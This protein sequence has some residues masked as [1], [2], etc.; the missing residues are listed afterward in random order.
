MARTRALHTRSSVPLELKLMEPILG[1]TSLQSGLTHARVAAVESLVAAFD[2]D[3]HK[4][5]HELG[6]RDGATLNVTTPHEI[7]L[8]VMERDGDAVHF[9]L[10]SSTRLQ[11]LIDAYCQREDLQRRNAVFTY[12][13]STGGDHTSR[14]A[15]TPHALALA[16]APDTVPLHPHA[17]ATPTSPLRTNHSTSCVNI[18]VRTG[19][20]GHGRCHAVVSENEGR[21]YRLRPPDT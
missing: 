9:K 8:K 18:D 13:V 14:L 17:R 7:N 2:V 15:H 6:L 4:S 5:P 20:V 21:R 1:Q 12:N 19:H 11:K 3:I 10:K 16:L